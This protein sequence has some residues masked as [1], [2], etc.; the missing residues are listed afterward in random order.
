M[1]PDPA[2][3]LDNFVVGR[4]PCTSIEQMRTYDIVNCLKQKKSKLEE[5]RSRRRRTLDK[6]LEHINELWTML[7]ISEEDEDRKKFIAKKNALPAYSLEQLAVVRFTAFACNPYHHEASRGFGV[8]SVQRRTAA[9]R[10]GQ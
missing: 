5:E 3:E 6:T 1:N 8:P 10:E 2:N 4:Q 7:H 9:T